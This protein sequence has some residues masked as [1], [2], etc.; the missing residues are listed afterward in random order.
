[1]KGKKRTGFFEND[2]F[3]N[4]DSMR[5][6]GK[7]HFSGGCAGKEVPLWNVAY[8]GGMDI[9]GQQPREGLE[10]LGEE[11]ELFQGV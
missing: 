3:K 7:P 5:M 1:M 2:A 4:N 8:E 6:E 11:R 10:S 9:R